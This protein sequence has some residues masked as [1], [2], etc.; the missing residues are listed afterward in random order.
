MLLT[1]LLTIQAMT[2]HSFAASDDYLDRNLGAYYKYVE[3]QDAR[4]T[5]W[6][7]L[8]RDRIVQPASI[9]YDSIVNKTYGML[10]QNLTYTAPVSLLMPTSYSIGV[11]PES[12]YTNVPDPY[13]DEYIR[14]YTEKINAQ[15]LQSSGLN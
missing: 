8:E 15:L 1:I 10:Q 11:T 6:M 12:F 9:N 2:L 14:Y 7:H 4:Y 13:H 3:G 5:Q